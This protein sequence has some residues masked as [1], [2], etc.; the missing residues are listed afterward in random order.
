[1]QE[2]QW[3]IALALREH[4]ACRGLPGV[5]RTWAKAPGNERSILGCQAWPSHSPYRAV[6]MEGDALRVAPRPFFGL[7]YLTFKKITKNHNEV[8]FM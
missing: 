7:R 4:L 1:M 8:L 3:Q 5:A 6:S 2:A